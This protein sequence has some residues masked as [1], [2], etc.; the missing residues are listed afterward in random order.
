MIFDHRI[1]T[2]NIILLWHHDD[3]VEYIST[4]V[5]IKSI[6]GSRYG[7]EAS[8]TFDCKT[9]AH[10]FFRE[11]KGYIEARFAP[12]GDPTSPHT[13]DLICTIGDMKYLS[14]GVNRFTRFE[15][16]KDELI[17]RVRARA[18]VIWNMFEDQNGD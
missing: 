15:P 12:I 4:S 3:L 1:T 9:E 2:E 14:F 5:S 13:G 6:N 18:T 10:E 11:P 8:I 16:S 17:F 7:P